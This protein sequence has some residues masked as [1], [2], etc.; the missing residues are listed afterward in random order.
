MSK[1][2]ENYYKQANVMPLLLKQKMSKLQ[3]N[4]DIM[5][6]FEYWIEHKQY[7]QNG[8][9]IKGYTARSLAELSVYTDGEGRFDS[10][11]CGNHHYIP[12]EKRNYDPLFRAQFTK[13]ELR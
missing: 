1:I 2:I 10:L 8:V 4:E 6:E 11:R 7:I 12:R 3:R 13:D 9:S 5:S